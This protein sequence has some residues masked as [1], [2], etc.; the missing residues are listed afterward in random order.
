MGARNETSAVGSVTAGSSSVM[1]R[2]TGA[3]PASGVHASA[4]DR[5]STAYFRAKPILSP[6]GV[7]PDGWA[8]P[9]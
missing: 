7:I 6:F 5:A 8:T 1:G 2:P 4:M 9:P 3:Q